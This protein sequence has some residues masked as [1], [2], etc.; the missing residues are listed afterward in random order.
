MLH[1]HQALYARRMSAGGEI[2]YGENLIKWSI[3][4][5][6]AVAVEEGHRVMTAVNI[7]SLLNLLILNDD[8]AK[9]NSRKSCWLNF[10]GKICR[11]SDKNYSIGNKTWAGGKYKIKYLEAIYYYCTIARNFA[12]I[13][14]DICRK[15]YELR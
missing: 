13:L 2:C 3:K 4:I 7:G 15:I 8:A 9:K 5:Q 6:Y 12:N 14:I 10:Y 11:Y 1:R